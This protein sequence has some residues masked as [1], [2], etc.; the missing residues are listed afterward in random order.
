MFP[1]LHF[2]PFLSKL[3]F[4]VLNSLGKRQERKLKK[5]ISCKFF[6]HKID[7]EDDSD[8]ELKVISVLWSRT[9][10]FHFLYFSDR[11]WKMMINV[12]YFILKVRFVFRIFTFLSW[13]FGYAEKRT[14]LGRFKTVLKA[15]IFSSISVSKGN[16]TMK[17][18]QLIESDKRNIFLQKSCR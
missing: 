5:N 18:G 4:N 2:R 15:N 7:R 11:P 1:L 16:Q 3:C 14:W 13:I 10:T 9:V 17:V 8:I 6:L 12:F